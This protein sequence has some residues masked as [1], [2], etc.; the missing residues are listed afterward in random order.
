MSVAAAALFEQIERGEKQCE[1]DMK[2]NGHM[3]S[4]PSQAIQR[5]IVK[6]CD[7]TTCN[8]I[9]C[10]RSNLRDPFRYIPIVYQ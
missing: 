6:D 1:C 5:H 7:C 4:V 9:D 3:S 2:A 8:P 10:F